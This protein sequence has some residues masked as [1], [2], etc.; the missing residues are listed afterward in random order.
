MAIQ[1]N[2]RL[3]PLFL[4]ALFVL[5]AC[6]KPQTSNEVEII[7]PPQDDDTWHVTTY[8]DTFDYSCTI[9]DCS[10]RDAVY[11]A[12]HAGRPITIYL[13]GGLHVLNNI[14][15]GG[16]TKKKGEPSTP[17]GIED[18]TSIYG[19]L[20]ILKGAD[21][22][23]IGDGIDKSNIDARSVDRIFHVVDVDANLE[24]R[25]ITL[26]G[27]IAW[28]RE[29]TKDRFWPVCVATPNTTLFSE[30]DGP[31]YNCTWSPSGTIT[32]ADYKREIEEI[33]GGAIANRGTLR[34]I[35]VSLLHNS[36]KHRGGG[37]IK[38]KLGSVY[39]EGGF[40]CNNSAHKGGAIYN[41]NG[42]LEMHR[43]GFCSNVA[44]DKGSAIYSSFSDVWD[45]YGEGEITMVN[46]T[47]GENIAPNNAGVIYTKTNTTMKNVTIH[48]N[49]SIG[50]VVKKKQL[51]MQNTLLSENGDKN[52]DGAIQTLGNNMESGGNCNLDPVVDTSLVQFPGLGTL[53]NLGVLYPLLSGSPSIDAGN[54]VLP[55]R[56]STRRGKHGQMAQGAILVLMSFMK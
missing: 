5:A 41:I 4:I 38:N 52:C 51:K 40:I 43:V 39:M 53:S 12:N 34:L 18:D 49:S 44:F 16:L 48:R 37:A 21:I 14:E 11:Q 25:G 29:W 8:E 3:I 1:N 35:D 6:S 47:M 7:P 46:V 33:G 23:I 20:D 36:S 17:W 27:G 42:K 10:L 9:D 50:I 55:V 22:T 15:Q 26:L 28:D 56:L 30:R 45:D 13:P 19:D 32:A 54:T 24:L 2:Y 31:K